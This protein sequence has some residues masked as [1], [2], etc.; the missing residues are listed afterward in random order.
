MESRPE[1]ISRGV[2]APEELIDFI[3]DFPG[4]LWRVDIIRNRIEYLNDN[5]IAG[6]GEKSGLLLQNIDF[7]RKVILPDDFR[8]FE[9][10]M[11][12]LRSGR[13]MATIFR[14]RVDNEV[15]WIKLTGN[16][17]RHNPNYFIGFMLDVSDTAAIVKRIA[18]H[19]AEREAMIEMVD[20]P[21]MLID[22]QTKAVISSNTA[23]GNLFEYRP[24]EFSRLN[25]QEL[26]HKTI[27]QQVSRI[28][29]ELVFEKSWEGKLHFQR[30]N[31]T[32]FIGKVSLMLLFL[33]GRH[34]FRLSIH[35]IET[36]DTG[37]GGLLGVKRNLADN[38]DP[39]KAA[40]CAKLTRMI[41]KKHDMSQI[42]NI[43]LEN[44][45][46]KHYFDSI[47]Y[48]DVYSKKGR[49]CVYTAGIP[50]ANMQQGQT[51]PYEGTIAENIDR[52]KLDYL[53]VDDTFSSIKPIDWALFIP[54]GIKSYFA[55]PFYERKL[56][57][58]VLILCSRERNMFSG[59]H[60]SEYALL[61]EPFLKG[62]Q[63]WRGWNR[64][65]AG[66]KTV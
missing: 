5:K 14:V 61:Y 11:K 15:R 42:L 47:I 40:H 31:N 26:C 28:C 9:E 3:S 41:G 12:A 21:V 32:S 60:L 6:L 53:L 10:F 23:A 44:Q 20:N 48:S 59:K 36:D 17:D 30:K 4:L 58:T 22:A 63:N 54:H 34:L 65:K 39:D 24:E 25:F 13:T 46:G 35:D 16:R 43:L 33:K 8:Y 45:R 38:L 55:Q 18:E 50:F 64:S 7:S 51:F 49:V 29:E 19:D 2:I 56:I 52:F 66:R 27:H 62:L 37:A 1:N 57:R